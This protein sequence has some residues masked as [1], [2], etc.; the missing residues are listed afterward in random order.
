[1]RGA[2]DQVCLTDKIL[3]NTHSIV[4]Q[5]QL[6]LGPINIITVLKTMKRLL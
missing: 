5:I 4:R 1:M 6:Y 3:K 2:I